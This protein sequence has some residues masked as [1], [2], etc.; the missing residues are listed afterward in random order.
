MKREALSEISI[1]SGMDAHRGAV[2]SRGDQAAL[3]QAEIPG[4]VAEEL[5][6]A[7]DV[8]RDLRA[9]AS[10]ADAEHDGSNQ[11]LS[12]RGSAG[13]VESSPGVTRRCAIVVGWRS[14]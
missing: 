11:F 7:T 4:R 3:S 12:T 8:V 5:H 10:D 9:A 1:R 14:S 6:F 2:A 13:V